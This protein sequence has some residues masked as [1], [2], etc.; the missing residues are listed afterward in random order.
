MYE[1]IMLSALVLSIGGNLYLF[2]EGG[3]LRRVIQEAVDKVERDRSEMVRIPFNQLKL[4][5]FSTRHGFYRDREFNAKP[6]PH[7]A[8]LS[9]A[10]RRKL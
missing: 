2:T 3:K 4:M 1:I 10:R 8:R 7:P 9:P 5:G 6:G